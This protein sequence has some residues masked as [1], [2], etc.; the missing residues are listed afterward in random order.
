MDDVSQKKVPRFV[1]RELEVM[2][3]DER[4]VILWTIA[5]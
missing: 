3:T 5:D 4:P 2:R 1:S